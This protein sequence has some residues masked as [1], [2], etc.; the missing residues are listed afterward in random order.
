VAACGT[1]TA[2]DVA[3]CK[4]YESIVDTEK[5]QVYGMA[6]ILGW[7]P[8]PKSRLTVTKFLLLIS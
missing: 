2:T 4:F 5:E 8:E 1:G 7:G 6:H 3:K